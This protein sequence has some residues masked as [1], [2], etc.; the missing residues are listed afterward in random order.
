M[1]Q[2]LKERYDLLV[3]KVELQDRAGPASDGIEARFTLQG[4]VE[5]R[6]ATLADLSHPGAVT[7]LVDVVS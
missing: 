3:L 2:W 1:A 7:G 5:G 6:L 4:K